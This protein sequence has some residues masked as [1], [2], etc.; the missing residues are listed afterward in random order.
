[1]H[2]L[3][4][5]IRVWL[6]S[7]LGYWVILVIGKTLR[8]E[9]KGWETYESVQKQGIGAI[10]T[11][12]HGRIFP[13]TYFFRNRGIVVMTSR[14]KDGDYIARVIRR[15]GYGAAR[16][17]STRGSRS[18]ILEMACEMVRRKD[19]AF[20]IDGPRGPRYVAKPGAIWLAWKTGAAAIPFNISA[21]RKWVLRSWDHFMIP[22]PFTRAFLLFGAPI[23]VDGDA[24]AEKLQEAQ[25]TL[26]QSLDM[27]REQSDAHWDEG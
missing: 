22:M 1:M 6:V 19:T 13:G 20:S 10:L 2:N 3:C 11:F 23:R 27:L 5:R 25:R 15:F 21:K 26:Q 14:H 4:H 24:T 17:S 8:W 18:A 12:W 7:E 9:V 16:G